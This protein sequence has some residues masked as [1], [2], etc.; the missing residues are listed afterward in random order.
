[1][2]DQEETGT[3]CNTG[4]AHWTQGETSPWEQHSPGTGS[5]EV[6]ASPSLEIFIA[7]MGKAQSAPVELE[8]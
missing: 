8:S 2:E 1:M 7:Q 4:K 6:L 5:G 3:R